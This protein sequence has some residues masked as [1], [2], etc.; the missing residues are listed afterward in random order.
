MEICKDLHDRGSIP[1]RKCIAAL[2]GLALNLKM[3]HVTLEL[4]S[5]SKT[6]E[7]ISIRC[8]RI[9]ALA[10][11]DRTDDIVIEIKAILKR[12]PPERNQFYSDVVSLPAILFIILYSLQKNHFEV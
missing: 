2:G 4:V 10:D 5:L 3:P 8:L 6:S 7:Y 9:M 1:L 11:L 12:G